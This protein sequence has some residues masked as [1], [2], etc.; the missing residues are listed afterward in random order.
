MKHKP[1]ERASDYHIAQTVIDLLAILKTRQTRYTIAVAL[2]CHHRTAL[3]WLQMMVQLKLAKTVLVPQTRQRGYVAI[4][5]LVP[6]G[7]KA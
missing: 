5:K 3:R 7:G 4:Q 1:V 2:N 6:R